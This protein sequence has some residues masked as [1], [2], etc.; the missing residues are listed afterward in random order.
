MYIYT[1]EIDG[2]GIVAAYTSLAKAKDFV[3]ECYKS[4]ISEDTRQKVNSYNGKTYEEE[5]RESLENEHY[6]ECYAYITT[7]EL[8]TEGEDIE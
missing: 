6:I 3:W 7:V 5:D 2:S 1:V 8:N 4:D